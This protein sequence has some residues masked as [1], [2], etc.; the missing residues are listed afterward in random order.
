MIGITNEGPRDTTDQSFNEQARKK[1]V[2]QQ[3]RKKRTAE[4]HQVNAR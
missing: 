2:N 3:A 1:Q 4:K